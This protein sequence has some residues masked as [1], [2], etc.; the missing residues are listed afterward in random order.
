MDFL[1]CDTLDSKAVDFKK[2]QPKSM[3]LKNKLLSKA[4][5]PRVSPVTDSDGLI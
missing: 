2:A 5:Q 1:L 3:G 4:A